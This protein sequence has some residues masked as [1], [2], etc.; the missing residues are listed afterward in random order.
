MD[1]R[2]SR[3]LCRKTLISILLVRRLS[4][5]ASL[6]SIHE[7]ALPT[8][9]VIPQ[10]QAGG[11]ISYDFLPNFNPVRSSSVLRRAFLVSLADSDM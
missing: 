11:E 5:H 1:V 2:A 9:G 4:T 8:W 7:Q 6:P 10:F 3:Q